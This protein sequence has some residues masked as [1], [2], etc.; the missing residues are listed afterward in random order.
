VGALARKRGMRLATL[1][2]VL[3][4]LA[5]G[6]VA[7]A[8]PHDASRSWTASSPAAEGP[9]Y[10]LVWERGGPRLVGVDPATFS[11]LPGRG[12]KL[13]ESA[14]AWAF[15]PDRTRLAF[16]SD[17]G[18]VQIVDPA[19]MRIVRTI[20]SA[21]KPET[22]AWLAPNRLVWAEPFH[23]VAADPGSGRVVRGTFVEFTLQN[24]A[25]AP[26]A[27][28]LLAAPNAGFGR[29]TLV[30]VGPDGRMR[31]VALPRIRAGVDYSRGVSETPIGRS[32]GLAVDPQGGRAFVVGGGEP[33]AQ[34][35]LASLAVR[36]HELG[37]SSSFLSRLH[38]WLD[39]AALAK[40]LNGP[41]RQALWLGNDLLAVTGADGR[42]DKD[43]NG[44]SMLSRTP[45]GV[46]LVDVRT[47]RTRRIDDAATDV[48]L[49]G[50]ALAAYGASY[51][52][53]V[54]RNVGSGL[55]LYRPDGTRIAH[56]FGSEPAWALWPVGSRAL[57][58]VSPRVVIVD[59]DDATVIGPAK[60]P[61]TELLVGESAG[62]GR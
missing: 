49:A 41:E 46:T 12:L 44:R 52:E 20:S 60:P 55:S 59:L 43:V 23:V 30:L 24:S 8:S 47:W 33:V 42:V 39:P 22:I 28:V 9:L 57:V 53:R 48:S 40:G 29:A 35:D 14:W 10:G 38:G 26:G 45:V 6:A 3:A 2:V 50:S 15:S 1:F 51:D 37:G 17:K 5:V 62:L 31:K 7:F 19:R 21:G 27:L 58:A 25:V 54:Q 61:M 36:F 16:A 18:G 11:A 4:A 56:L 34:V 32:P 13:G